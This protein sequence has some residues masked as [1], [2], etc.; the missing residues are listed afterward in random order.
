MPA[1]AV[2]TLIIIGNFESLLSNS[3]ILTSGDSL[4]SYCLIKRRY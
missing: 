2:E 4:L 3:L 1:V